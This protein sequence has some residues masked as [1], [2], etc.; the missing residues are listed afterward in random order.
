MRVS[1]APG[2]TAPVMDHHAPVGVEDQVVLDAGKRKIAVEL[3][4][5]IVRRGS[6]A[7]NAAT[8]ALFGRCS[9]PSVSRR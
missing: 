5:V 7:Q 4:P 1:I 9:K 6:A 3:D 2:L 8:P